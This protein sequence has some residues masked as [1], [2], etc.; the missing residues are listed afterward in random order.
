MDRFA[1]MLILLGVLVVCLFA[2][3]TISY[4][5]SRSKTYHF[6]YLLNTISTVPKSS[7]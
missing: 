6:L 5:F 7:R 4:L 1:A 2:L 3:V